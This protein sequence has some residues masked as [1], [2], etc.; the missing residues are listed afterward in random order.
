MGY[1]ELHGLPYQSYGG[2][3]PADVF[4]ARQGHVPR[5]RRHSRSRHHSGTAASHALSEALEEALLRLGRHD[6][7][8]CSLVA[9]RHGS[10]PQRPTAPIAPSF[11]AV[12]VYSLGEDALHEPFLVHPEDAVL[13]HLAESV[14]GVR[15]GVVVVVDSDLLA[16]EELLAGEPL[17]RAPLNRR[18]APALLAQETSQPP[19]ELLARHRRAVRRVL[20]LLLASEERSE[21]V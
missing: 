4:V 14:P 12:R 2:A 18:R 7:F 21:V 13:T 19:E 5:A 10:A 1:R 15:R 16:R 9:L 20:G 17:G 3:H 6:L 8:G 11:V